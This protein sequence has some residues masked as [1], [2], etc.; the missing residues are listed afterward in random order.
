MNMQ[1]Q[2]LTTR[3]FELGCR[4]HK[5]TCNQGPRWPYHRGGKGVC[6]THSHHLGP[7]RLKYILEGGPSQENKAL[8]IN[9]MSDY[10]PAQKAA[11]HSNCQRA[12]KLNM[13]KLSY[14]H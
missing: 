2:P 8:E 12:E 9:K 14:T 6:C 1:A 3:T 4:S 13:N 11:H 10:V 7:N 5:D